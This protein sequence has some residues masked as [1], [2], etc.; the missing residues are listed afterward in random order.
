K[1]ARVNLPADQALCAF[2]ARHLQGDVR[3]I[4]G[5]IG[6]LQAHSE[7]LQKPVDL[8]LCQQL[9]GDAQ[10]PVQPVTIAAIQRAVCAHYSVQL[11]DLLS[12]RRSRAIVQPRHVAMYLARELTVRSFPEIGR[13]F[14]DRD[15]STVYHAIKQIERKK[16]HDIE[17][18]N[19][20]QH[21]TRTLHQPG[22]GD[23]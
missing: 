17:L 11:K 19:Q 10:M 5:F 13:M 18:A 14:G 12:A 9:L 1:M 6:S 8:A 7:L 3:R 21:I 20:L 16:L 22:S 15:H 2:L 23:L 4:E